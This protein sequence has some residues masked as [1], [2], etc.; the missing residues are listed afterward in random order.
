[1]KNKIKELSIIKTNDDY[2]FNDNYIIPIYQ[3][4]FSW[5]EKE[6]LEFIE[7]IMNFKEEYYYVGSLVVNLIDES[8]YEVIDGQQRLI[9]IYLL[10]SLLGEKLDLNNLRFSCRDNYNSYLKLLNDGVIDLQDVHNDSLIICKSIIERIINRKEFNKKEFKERLNHV[11]IYR[12][13]VPENTDLNHYF[14]VMNTRGEQLEQHDILKAKLM[15]FIENADHK[16][17]FAKVWEACSDMDG[18]VQMN[19]D[20]YLRN[21]IFSSLW[22]DLISFDNFKL[23]NLNQK[24]ELS[25]IVT[26]KDI[27]KPEFNVNDISESNKKYEKKRFESI[28]SFPYFLLHTLKVYLNVNKVNIEVDGMDDK[29]LIDVFENVINEVKKS[30]KLNDFSMEFVYF[31]LKCRFYFDKYIIKR[32]FINDEVDGKWSLKELVVYGQASKKHP[33]YINTIMHKKYEKNNNAYVRLNNVLM[34]ESCLR[35][36]YTSN[37]SMHWVTLLLTFLCKNNIDDE[38][39]RIEEVIEDNIKKTVLEDYLNKGDFKMGV[40]TPHIVLN[41]LDYLIWKK[42]TVKYKNFIFE[43]RNSV[44]HWYPKNPS[45]DT[46]SK[47]DNVD[48]LGNL[49]II[50]SNVNSKFSNMSPIAK[51]NT[52]EEMIKK[53]SLKLIKM[54]DK[55]IVNDNESGNEYWKK[56]ACLEHEKEMLDILYQSCKL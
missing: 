47:W 26:I 22:S 18:Y 7:D 52:F 41:Y 36:T 38:L 17:L 6:I 3:R 33:Q 53:G 25:N 15:S 51:K 43:Y 11:K 28:T 50:Q 45:D 8:N 44:E 34:L 14:E 35:V 1:M 46:F 56:V 48:T 42:E 55:T 4:T 10:L 37:K 2:I 12:I 21:S 32:E 13:V 39:Y 20:V 9:V 31:L 30:N 24:D 23:I 40:D 27:I 49:C 5:E 54:S 19:F 29:L 16:E